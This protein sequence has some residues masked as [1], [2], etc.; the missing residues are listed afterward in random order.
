LAALSALKEQLNQQLAEV[1]KQEKAT[2]ESLRP[3][4]VAQVDELQTKLEAALEE[5]KSQR[6]ELEQ[7]EKDQQQK[8]PPPQ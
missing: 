4:S 8:E 6:A 3:Q 5:L 7:K 2:E 1:E